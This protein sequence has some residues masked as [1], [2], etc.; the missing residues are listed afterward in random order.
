[1]GVFAPA[2]LKARTGTRLKVVFAVSAAARVTLRLALRSSTVDTAASA[3][4]GANG[5]RITLKKGRKDL[6]AG[7]YTLTLRGP[8]GT[9]LSE[10][11]VRVT[12]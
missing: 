9:H 3:S 6:R 12:A 10:T 8:D 11:R 1:M 2:R 4:A 5:V 7:T